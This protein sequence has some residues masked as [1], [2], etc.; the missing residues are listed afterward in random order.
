MEPRLMSAP[1]CSPGSSASAPRLV[2]ITPGAAR[3]A[4]WLLVHPAAPNS[5]VALQLPASPQR[6]L[7][8]LQAG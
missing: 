6:P 5:A 1:D 7:T 2:W 8:S 4:G 3:I